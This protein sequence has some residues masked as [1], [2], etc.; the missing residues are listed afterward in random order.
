MKVSGLDWKN[1]GPC[2][3]WMKP[4]FDEVSDQFRPPYLF[5]YDEI[6]PNSQGLVRNCPTILTDDSHIIQTH[7]TSMDMFVSISLLS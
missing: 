7:T 1:L 5:E 4:F 6:V 2:V 3:A